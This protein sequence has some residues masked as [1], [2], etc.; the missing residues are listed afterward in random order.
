MY[1]IGVSWKIKKEIQLQQNKVGV[2]AEP[3]WSQ[4]KAGFEV[5]FSNFCLALYVPHSQGFP[6]RVSH[7]DSQSYEI[8]LGLYSSILVKLDDLSSWFDPCY[9]CYV[10]VEDRYLTF[11]QMV[12]YYCTFDRVNNLSWA[13]KGPFQ[14]ERVSSKTLPR[15]CNCYPVQSLPMVMSL[16]LVPKIQ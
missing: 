7:H 15:Y 12:I 13:S 5:R 10:T 2:R 1:N 8:L 9:P 3:E 6:L 11:C 4:S 16:Q 14:D